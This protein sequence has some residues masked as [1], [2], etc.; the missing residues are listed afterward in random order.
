MTDEALPES[1][2]LQDAPHPRETIRLFG[3]DEAERTLLDAIQGERMHHAWLI[4]GPKGVGKATLAWRAARFLLTRPPEGDGGLFGAPPKAESLDVPPDAPVARRI[5]AM[6]EP[7]L[8]AIRRPWDTDKKRFKTQITVDEVRRLNGFFGL[9][10]AE[11]GHRVVIIDSVDEMNTAAANALLKLLEEPPKHAILFLVSHRPARLLPTI[12]SRCRE[13]R[14]GSLAPEDLASALSQAGRSDETGQEL[15][16][17]SGGSVG[18]ALRLA[19]LD[20]AGLYA[21]LIALFATAPSMDR[22]AAAKLVEKVAQRGA[23]DRFDLICVLI[24]IALTRLALTGAGQM[25][26]VQAATEEHAVLARL[27]PDLSRAKAWAELKSDLN[28]RISH[29]RAVNVDPA[30]LLL[31]VFLKFN[32]TAGQP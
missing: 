8:M 25:P 9:S 17:L 7:G 31:D 28:D 24:D 3:Q 19:E 23:E 10:A 20:G 13:L 18:E 6:S 11:G 22:Q 5:A 32:D 30:T 12:R 29:G 26:A 14:L 16:E 2:R 27:A 1:D 15:A 4:T 21:S